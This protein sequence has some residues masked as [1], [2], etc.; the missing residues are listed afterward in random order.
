MLTKPS[1]LAA[2]LIIT[3]ILFSG[4]NLLPGNQPTTDNSKQ[5]QDQVSNQSSETV[6]PSGQYSINELL[7]M[8][9]PLKCTWKESATGDSDI[10]NIMYLNGKKFYQD[11][12]M[13][14]IG[15]SFT[16]FDGDWLYIW[17]DFNAMASKMKS[18]EVQ[19]NFKPGQENAQANATMEQK[20]DFLCENW[21]VDNSIFNPP[22]DKNFKDVTSEMNQAFQES[23]QEGLE[24][25]K[26]QMC[27][28]CQKAPD[29][30]TKNE[31]LKNA[32]CDQ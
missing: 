31:C 26:Q 19:T 20:K 21:A 1:Y 12:T 24:K 32:E 25:A 30:D 4:C 17:N 7:T 3:A 6:N 11:V 29:Q 22:Q 10:T 16:I 23:G 27:D 2:S 15:H 13:G 9:K 5:N 18:T 28:L 8:N 14:E